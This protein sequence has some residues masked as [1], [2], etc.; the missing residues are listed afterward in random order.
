MVSGITTPMKV[1]LVQP[2]V[3]WEDHAA[4]FEKIRGLL[5]RS[6][7]DRGSLIV[8]PEMF[9][10][11]FS[12]NLEATLRAESAAGSFLKQ[13][14]AEH[15]CAVIGGL[16]SQGQQGMGRN[17]AVA[18]GPTGS[19]LARYCKMQPFTLGG[20][21]GCHEKG[22]APVFFEWDGFVVSPFVCYDL[23]FPELFRS[24]ARRGAE[25]LVV[26]AQWPSRRVQ[27]WVTLLQAR[28]IENQAF[29]V[30]V[31]RSGKDPTLDYPGRSIVVNPMGEIIADAGA[32]EGVVSAEL[33]VAT[34]LQWRRDFPALQ[35]MRTDLRP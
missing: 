32:G 27:H 18:H 2:D 5:A 12:M 22:E 23:R 30:G 3:V 11:G 8:L 29:V 7:I 15:Q 20:E 25:L 26:I 16:V 28:A 9:A 19:L 31:N 24:A 33:D 17:E 4:N 34:V 6:A 13:L 10:T 1:L 14:A 21:A 35:D